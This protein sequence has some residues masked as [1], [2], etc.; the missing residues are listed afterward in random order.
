MKLIVKKMNITSTLLLAISIVPI[1]TLIVSSNSYYSKV[2]LI[3]TM[4]LLVALYLNVYKMSINKTAIVILSLNLLSIFV[5][6]CFYSALGSAITFINTIIC[7]KLFN[8]IEIDKKSY[9]LIHSILGV[10]LTCYVFAIPKPDYIGHRV[11][12]AFNNPVNTN[13]ISILYLCAFLHIMCCVFQFKKCRKRTILEIILILTYGYNIW[14]YGA[15]SAIVSLIVFI[16][17]IVLIKNAIPYSVYK[18][19]ITITL[20]VS[21]LFPIIYLST[22]DR[23]NIYEFLGKGISSR[24]IVWAGCVNIIKEHPLLGV[25]NDISIQMRS[26]GELTTSMHNT[27]LGLW[28]ILG[29]IPT[30]TFAMTCINHDNTVYDN[31][32][33]LVSQLAFISTLIICFFES[34]Y[35]EELLYLAFLPFLICNVKSER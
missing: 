9:M 21:L 18:R 22:I 33:M 31:K 24:R 6:N 13:I 1:L 15:R 27:L 35:T 16:I 29:L 17:C 34:F 5:T 7:F 23:F 11:N 26:S 14:F 10:T 8:N 28:K 30:I 3:V 20:F 32:K 25:G 19:A 4:L 12:D 2:V